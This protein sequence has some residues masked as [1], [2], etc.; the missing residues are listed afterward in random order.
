MKKHIAIVLTIIFMF[1]SLPV[2]AESDELEYTPYINGYQDGTFRPDEH[3]S[4]AEAISMVANLSTDAEVIGAANQFT[5]VSADSWYNDAVSDLSSKGFLTNFSNQLN[6]DTPISRMQMV[7]LVYQLKNGASNLSFLDMFLKAIEDGII[8]GDGG[9]YRPEANLTRAEAVTMLNRVLVAKFG[10]QNTSMLYQA[11]FSDVT[12]KHWAFR[13]ILLA[14]VAAHQLTSLP[15]EVPADYATKTFDTYN[16]AGHQWETIPMVTKEMKDQGVMGGEGGQRLCGFAISSDGQTLLVGTDV[17]GYWAS[18]NGGETWEAGFGG[19]YSRGIFDFCFDP[20]NEDRVLAFGGYPTQTVSSERSNATNG[21]YLSL[22][23]GR[24]W[25]QVL[26]QKNANMMRDF[27]Q[28]IAYDKTSYDAEKDRCMV[29]YWSRPWHLQGYPTM[30]NFFDESLISVFEGD[31]KGLWKTEDGGETWFLVNG[32]MSDGVVKVNPEN[33]TV[34]VANFNGFHIST[35]GGKTFQT[36]LGGCMIY[37]LDVIDAYPNRVYVND[38]KSVLVSEDSGKTF[39]RI[40]SKNF[41]KSYDITNPDRIVKGLKVSPVNPQHM[42][43]ADFQGSSRYC[44]TKYFSTDGGVNWTLSEYDRTGDFLKANNRDTNFLWSPID[45]NKV[46]AFGG[47]HIATSSDAGKTYHWDYN[48]GA[49]ICVTGRSAFNL[50]NPDLLYYGSQDFHGAYTKDGGETWK[51]IWKATGSQGAGF[52]YGAYAAD[53]NTLICL[54]STEKQID[55]VGTDG[56]WDG[57]REIRVSRDGGETF[58][59]T[60]VYKLDNHAKKWSER[61]YQSPNNPD[62]LFAANF[63]SDDYGYTWEKMEDCDV[64]YTHNPYGKKELY[65]AKKDKVV[66]SY[67]DGANW[68]VVT[69]VL[70]PKSFA[71]TPEKTEIWDV[72]YD[73]VN[74]IIYYVSGINSGGEYFAKYENGVTTDLTS[75]IVTTYY[76]KRFQLVEVDPRYPNVVYIGGCGGSYMEENGIQRSV[77]GAETFQVLSANGQENTIVKSGPAHGF[78]VRDLLVHPITG[79]LWAMNSTRGWAKIAPPYEN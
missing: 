57:V 58:V 25:K 24:T 1:A 49:A 12:N 4:V 71:E 13:D 2:F 53:E 38:Y 61:C 66:V 62:V 37:G 70:I 20:M 17:A 9:G 39:E 65:G 21:I 31:Q 33:G 79:E 52:V 64:V 36:I 68:E 43:I 29:A 55:G 76:G 54:A 34:Y 74:D 77:D 15:A 46:F 22:D 50:F 18:Y 16:E 28:Q 75:N 5:D 11:A 26:V 72:A 78:L 69:T 23:R 6:P 63:R 3:V 27:R 14:S 60:G 7:S 40:E 51:H 47:D 59:K 73:G 8:V 30:K 35:D 45:E 56:G 44:S 41:P 67:D 19:M 10:E 32:E 42:V 48:G